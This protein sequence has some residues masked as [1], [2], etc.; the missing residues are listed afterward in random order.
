MGTKVKKIIFG[1]AYAFRSNLF[2]HLLCAMF[3]HIKSFVHWPLQI[4]VNH[5]FHHLSRITA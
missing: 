4:L 5:I 1:T 2:L 3:I